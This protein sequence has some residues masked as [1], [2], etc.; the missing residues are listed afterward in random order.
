MDSAN[1]DDLELP[2][3]VKD[4]TR[5]HYNVLK[6]EQTLSSSRHVG[7]SRSVRVLLNLACSN[8]VLVTFPFMNFTLIR[9]E[10]IL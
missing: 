7:H 3:L 1:F 4:V 2:T 9:L 5:N 8:V 10:V 6:R